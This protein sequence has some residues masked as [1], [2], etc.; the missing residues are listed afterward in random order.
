MR[1]KYWHEYAKTAGNI[2]PYPQLLMVCGIIQYATN[3]C[4][5]CGAWKVCNNI[6]HKLIVRLSWETLFGGKFVNKPNGCN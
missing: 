3:Y 5:K 4:I 6:L 2:A 1:V